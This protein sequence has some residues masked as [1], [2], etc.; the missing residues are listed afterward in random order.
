MAAPEIAKE[1][2]QQIV[3]TEHL[4]KALLEQPNGLARRVI[5]KAGSEPS[6]L[7][8]KTDAFIRKQPTVRGE[9]AQV[10]TNGEGLQRALGIAC[11]HGEEGH[12]RV[13]SCL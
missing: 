7:L 10:C 6:R 9:A 13:H 4:M 5:A 11:E 1:Y 2:Q 8:D 12:A 3:E